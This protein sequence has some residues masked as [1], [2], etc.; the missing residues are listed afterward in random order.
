V[1]GAGGNDTLLGESPITLYGGSGND[2]LIWRGAHGANG[3]VG[4]GGSGNDHLNMMDMTGGTGRRHVRTDGLQRRDHA[5]GNMAGNNAGGIV[6]DFHHG[7]DHL[8][9]DSYHAAPGTLTHSGD[10]WT[11]HDRRGISR[12]TSWAS[13]TS[14]RQTT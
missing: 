7:E 5:G 11:V 9:I 12:S 14:T 13:R 3:T 2:D 4:Y 10:I 8:Q 6:R 1:N